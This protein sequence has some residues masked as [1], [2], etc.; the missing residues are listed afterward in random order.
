MATSTG[1]ISTSA[2]PLDVANLVN[3]LVAVESKSRLTPLASKADGFN[4]LLAAY[5][6]LDKALGTYQSA[7]AGLTAARFSAQKAAVSNSGNAT[8]SGGEVKTGADAISADINADDSTRA[9]AQKIRSSGF[10]SGQLFR[11]GDSLAIKVGTRPPTFITL[12]ADAT[13]TGLRDTIN[14]ANAGVTASVTRDEAGEHLVLESNTGGTANT[15]SVRSNNSLSAISFDPQQQRPGAMTQTQAARDA[16]RAAAGSYAL[17]V[18]QLAQAHK[19]SSAGINPGTTFDVGVLAIKTGQ[20]ST[21]LIK[22]ANHTLA[23]VRDAINAAEAGVNASIV[24][25]GKQEHLVLTA[26]ESGA[27]NA[28]RVSGTGDFAVFASDPS[29]NVST[30]SVALEKRFGTGTVS[31]TV[32]TR[33]FSLSPVS[34]TAGTAPGLADV[35]SAINEAKTGVT[36]TVRREGQGDQAVERLVLSNGG[37]DAIRLRGSGDYAVLTASAMGQLQRPQDARLSIDGVAIT[38]PGNQIRDAISGVTLNLNK[39]TR[40]GD[41]FT[42]T[43]SNDNSGAKEAVNSFVNAFN[44][45]TKSVATLTRQVP[46]KVRGQAGE[47]GPLASETMVQALMGQ[48]RNAVLGAVSGNEHGSLAAIGVSFKKD[49]TLALDDA[50][51]SKAGSTSFDALARLFTDKG[52]VVTRSQALLDK[53][54]GETGLLAGKTRGLQ[55]SLKTVSDQQ[56]AAR[57]RLSNLRDSY[58]NQFNRLN[59]TLARMQASQS[60][61]TQQLARLRKT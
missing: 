28:I 21:A 13:V 58:T 4:A 20:G 7:L 15:L 55:S 6:S 31:L 18:E 57:E 27:Q 61:L 33:N 8:G 51:L 52:G 32:G 49:G 39:T 43:V 42:L 50:R 2:G 11:A 5:G 14:A 12:K 17:S 22:P 41:R 23:G 47:Q 30:A 35:A 46:S 48:L 1:S 34:S 38:A 29:G 3:Q 25:D 59:L 54:L 56:A 37:S 9:L 45:L 16:T 24:S 10:A 36:A 26:K 60:Y 44:A 19:L 40:S 53:V